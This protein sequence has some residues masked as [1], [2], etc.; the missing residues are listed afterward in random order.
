MSDSD[1]PSSRQP[2]RA[3]GPHRTVLGAMLDLGKAGVVKR[4]MHVERSA[5]DLGGEPGEVGSIRKALM[6]SATAVGNVLSKGQGSSTRRVHPT[7]ELEVDEW[8]HF[9]RSPNA[10]ARAA[11]RGSEWLVDLPGYTDRSERSEEN[12]PRTG[13]EMLRAAERRCQLS[14]RAPNADARRAAAIDSVRSVRTR[15]KGDYVIDPR[16]V[17]WVAYWDLMVGVLLIFIALSTPFEVAFFEETRVDTMFVVGRLIDCLFLIDV[18]LQFFMAFQTDDRM[19]G[20]IWVKDNRAI[21]CNYLRTWFIVDVIGMVPVDLILLHIQQSDEGGGVGGAR[22]EMKFVRLLRAMRLFKLLR[23]LRSNRLLRRYTDRIS[24]PYASVELVKLIAM[25]LLASHWMACIL[26]IIKMNVA[27][28]NWFSVRKSEMVAS[29]YGPLHGVGEQYVVALHF[30][31]MT[32]TS[33]GYGDIVPQ[34]TVEY[35]AL[36]VMQ[37][38]G[39]CTWTYVI[40]SACSVV[41]AL[42]ESGAAFRQTMDRLNALIKEKQLT[43]ALSRRLRR[44]F[45]HTARRAR[46]AGYTTL[47]YQMSY[48]LRACVV[49]TMNKNWLDHIWVFDGCHRDFV[50]QVALALEFHM[51][52]A[53]E[54]CYLDRTL[55]VLGR[56]IAA[57][58]G[59]VMARGAV[60]GYDILLQ[61]DDW[62]E[63]RRAFCFTF[64]EVQG[65][66]KAELD[67]IRR[68]FPEEDRKLRKASIYVALRLRVHQMRN[69][70][71]VSQGRLLD[72]E[73]APM[74]PE[75]VEAM[76]SVMVSAWSSDARTAG[77]RKEH[78]T[79]TGGRE[80]LVGHETAWGAKPAMVGGLHRVRSL[81]GPQPIRGLLDRPAASLHNM[82]SVPEDNGHWPSSPEGRLRHRG[83]GFTN[84]E[85]SESESHDVD[86]SIEDL[87]LRIQS[88]H[89]KMQRQAE[90]LSERLSGIQLGVAEWRL[91]LSAPGA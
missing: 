28:P 57:Y 46:I 15:T 83:R 75:L 91:S 4:T 23:V 79:T 7:H 82:V 27:E 17:G 62:T 32:V 10:K 78:R 48:G 80:D 58:A 87:E 33:I 16:Y 64:V 84:D 52:P 11:T 22:R 89:D 2:E 54:F 60:W 30:A 61:S 51:F 76:P 86:A 25:L 13:L 47:L 24:V 55:N 56:G 49:L 38:L 85:E 41:S 12:P 34:N 43:P 39:G 36:T 14:R 19:L 63:K 88:T 29:G 81:G 35:M 20:L 77:L 65:L 8:T 44:F 21:A 66:K 40:G 5:S 3:A 26:G 69:E 31:V 9:V 90:V 18:C 67:T 71:R 68:S 53:G 37:L 73:S 42:D 50:V 70:L 1:S 74:T 59:R 6:R 72:N 45:E